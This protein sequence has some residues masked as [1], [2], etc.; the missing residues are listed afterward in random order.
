MFEK[1]LTHHPF[2]FCASLI[3]GEH[4]LYPRAFNIDLARRILALE[5]VDAAAPRGLNG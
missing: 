1:V 4:Q 3:A 5:N 2:R